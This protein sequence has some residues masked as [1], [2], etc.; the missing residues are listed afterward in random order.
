[1]P[2]NYDYVLTTDIQAQI[3]QLGLDQSETHLIQQRVQAQLEREGLTPQDP[4]R[5]ERLRETLRQHLEA[6][7]AAQQGQR[8]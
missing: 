8:Q 3:R 4:Q 2:V 5:F 7:R 6:L 1:M